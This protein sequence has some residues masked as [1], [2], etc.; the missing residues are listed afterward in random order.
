MRAPNAARAAPASGGDP[1]KIEQLAGRLNFK[2]SLADALQQAKS[3]AALVGT[4]DPALVAGL[5][6]AL[7]AGPRQ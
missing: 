4:I 7:L 5:A 3:L 2:D 6:F 1:R